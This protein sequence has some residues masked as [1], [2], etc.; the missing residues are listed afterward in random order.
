M[1]LSG[2]DHV[3]FPDAVPRC[4]MRQDVRKE[5]RCLGDRLV[6][7]VCGRDRRWVLN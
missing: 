2:T 1:D 3:P 7:N 6:R 5:A 4:G